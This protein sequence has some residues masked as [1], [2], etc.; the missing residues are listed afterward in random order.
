[1]DRIRI[2]IG[3]IRR[4]HPA[5]R[6]HLRHAIA[7]RIRRCTNRRTT[8]ETAATVVSKATVAAV[9]EVDVTPCRQPMDRAAGS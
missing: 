1:M 8:Q 4:I 3:R 2:L 6:M 5:T 7:L 9:M